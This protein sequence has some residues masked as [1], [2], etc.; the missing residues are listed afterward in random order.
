MRNMLEKMNETR[1]FPRNYYIKGKGGWSGS[2]SHFWNVTYLPKIGLK[3]LKGRK[4]DTWRPWAPVCLEEFAK[5]YFKVYNENY[6]YEMLFVADTVTD[7][8]FNNRMK[9][10]RLQIVNRRKN[11][12]LSK[13]IINI[14]YG[15]SCT[16]KKI[17]QL[18]LLRA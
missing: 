4:T 2:F 5:S 13:S 18:S 12:L 1:L 8:W 10:A 6:N 3:R 17:S 11:L 7:K 15:I 14:F 16:S 9:N